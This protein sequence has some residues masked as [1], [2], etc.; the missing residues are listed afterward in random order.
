MFLLDYG[1]FNCFAH[2]KQIEFEKCNQKLYKTCPKRLEAE[3]AGQT[4]NAFCWPTQRRLLKTG[5]SSHGQSRFAQAGASRS[6]LV[7][8]GHGE[9]SV[10]VCSVAPSETRLHSSIA[11]R[12]ASGS[13]S[14]VFSGLDRCS[15]A[16]SRTRIGRPSAVSPP[17]GQLPKRTA[18]V[19]RPPDSYRSSG[20]NQQQDQHD[21]TPSLRLSGPG[22][23]RFENPGTP[24]LLMESH[25][26]TELTPML[27]KP[28]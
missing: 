22:V 21:E 18:G 11:D 24:P 15:S 10:I 19:I 28:H 8:V 9:S 2:K 3:S 13:I 4:F 12:A 20:R 26:R 25:W 5:V 17:I 1:G 14:K 6:K 23:L 27:V 7:S 16:E